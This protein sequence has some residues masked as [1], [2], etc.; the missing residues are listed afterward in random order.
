MKT[1]IIEL[2]EKE[3]GNREL[4]KEKNAEI[5]RLEKRLEEKERVIERLNKE[6]Q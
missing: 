4:V 6:N 3:V 2:E 5:S 1:I